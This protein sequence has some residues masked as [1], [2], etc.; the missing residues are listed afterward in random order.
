MCATMSSPTLCHE[1]EL[2]RTD[3]DLE[4]Y[5]VSDYFFFFFFFFF[6]LRALYLEVY[7]LVIPIELP[8]EIIDKW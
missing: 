8:S 6:F 1:L 3:Y 5:A 7:L 4:L 2:A